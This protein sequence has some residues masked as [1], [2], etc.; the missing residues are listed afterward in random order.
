[1]TQATALQILKLG[2]TTFLTGAA[3]AGKSYALREYI[4]YLKRHGIKYAVT[5]STGIA[6]THIN[7]M[8]I[9]SWSGIGIKQKLFAYDLDAL[10]EKQN[11]WKRWN[12]THVLIIDEISMLHASFVDMLDKI[13]KHMR[14][15]DK[16]FGG[17]QVIFTG[18]FFQLPPV[19]RHSDEYENKD[20][21]AFMATS[22]KEAKPVVCYLTEQFRQDDDKLTSILNAIRSGEIEDEHYE[23]LRGTHDKA[24]IEDHIK[25]Y[26]HNENVDEINMQAFNKMKGEVRTFQMITKGKAQ[27]VA[28]LKN[29]CLADEVLQLKVGAKVICIKNAQD[30]SYVNGSM[31]IVTSFDNEGAPVV[32]LVNG[33]KITVRADS[34]KIEEDGKVRAE[35]QQLPIRLAWAIT[36]HKSQ[37]MTLDR[38]EIDLSRSFASG[39]GYVALSRLKS[40]SGLHLKGFNP[41]ALMIAEQ[42]READATFRAKSAQAENAIAKYTDEQLGALH[43]T[44][45]LERG[46]SLVELDEVEAE[47]VAVKIPSHDKTKEML[48]AGMSII[49]IAEA[50]SFSVDTIIGHIEKLL[51]LKEEIELKHTLPPKKIMDVIKKTFKELKTTK[52][53]PVYEHLKGKYSYQ[54]IRIVRASIR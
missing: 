2:H 11:L 44:F 36:V 35:L 22:W 54:D 23:M 10:E 4:V 28:S 9:H 20:V 46:G 30:R 1:M 21:F 3:G 27:L 49:E 12:E 33:R 24:H 37:G 52:L 25:L 29:N 41:Q 43:D 53:T 39:Q 7:G 18:D 40:L 13:G 26:T 42:V 38:A 34:W 5:A 47:E 19:V 48:Q 45:L 8:T 16:P 32:E 14:R 15:N 6:S 51:D 31:G 50:R 17:I